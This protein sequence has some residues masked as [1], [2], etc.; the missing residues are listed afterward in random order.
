MNA[1]QVFVAALVCVILWTIWT[2]TKCLWLHLFVWYCEQYEH[3]PSVCGCTCLCDIVNNMNT[4][5]VFVAALVC[6][7]L[8]T[9]WTITKCLW[10]HLFAWYCEQYECSPSVC[11]CTCL[12][13]IV[14]NMN[15]HQVFVAALVCVILWTIWTL[16]KCLWLHLF[17]WYCEQYERSPSVCGYTCL[18]DIVNNMNTHQVFVATLVCV[19]LWTIWTLTKCLWL[20]LFAWYCEQYEHSPSVC[21]CTCL[22]DI[23]NN[24]NA[25]QVFVAALVCVILWTIWTLTKCLWLHLFAWYCEQ[26]EH[27]P[28]V[29]G[30]TCLRDIVNNMNT[31]QVFVAALVCVILWTMWMLTKCLWLHLFAWYCEQYEH[32]PSVCGYTCLCDIVNNMNAHQ[33]FVACL[34]LFAWYCEQYERSPSSP[35]VCGCTC[36]RDIVNNMNT[37]QVF[38]ATLVCVILWT[39]WTLTKCL[40]LHLFAWYCEQYEHSP[41]VCGCTCLRDIVNNMNAHQVFVAALVCVILW[42]I[43]TLTKCLWLHL[44]ACDI[45]NNMNTHQ[46]FVA[47]LVCVILWTTFHQVFVA[48]LVCVILWCLWLHL[49]AWYCEQYE[50][51]PSVCGCTCLRDIVNNMNAHQVFV[52]ALVC[53]ILWT[54]WTLTKC[55]WLHLFAWYCDI[56]NNM[57]THQVFVAALVCVILWTIWTLTKCL[58]LHLFAWYCEQHERSPSVCGCTCL[59]DIVNNMNTHQVF[60]AT[61]VCVILWTIWTLTKC[62]W[63]HLFLWYCEQY[64]HSPSVCGCTCLRDIVNN[65]N[66]HQVFVATLVCVILWTIWTLTK[67]LWLHLFAWYCEQYERSPSVCG[68]LHLFA[69]YCEQYEHSPSVCGCTCLRDIV[70]NMNAHQVFVAALVCVIL[71]T[72]WT[73]QVFVAHQVF[74]CGCTCL[75]DIVNNMNTHQVFVAALVCVILWT[76]WTLTKCLWLHLFAWYCEQYERSPSVC[77]CTCLRDI[78]NNMNTHQVFVA[79]LVC[80]C[81]LRDI[82]WTIWTLT[83]C[84]WLHLFAWYCEQYERSPSVC[85]CTCLCDIVNNM[86]THQVFVAALVCV[87]LWT[88]WTLTKCLW[89]HLFVWYCEQYEHSPSVCGC[90][91][92]C[93]IVNNMNTHQVFVAALVC[94]ILWTIWTITKCLWLHLFAWYCEQYECSPSVCGCTC[95]RDIVNNMNAHQVFVAALVCVILWTIWTLTKCLWLHLFVWY[96]EQYE[97]SPSVCGYTCLRDIVNNMNTHQ[98]FVATLVCVILWTIW[99]L[100]K[101]LWLHLFAWYCEQYEHS[102]SVCGC[103]CLC[104]IVNNMNAH[105]V[106][107]AALVCVILWTIWTLTKCLWLHLFAWYCEQYE[108]SPSVCGCT[109]LR[110]IVNNMNTHQVFVAA[111]VCVILWT[112]WMLTKFLWLHLFAWYCEQY[113]HSPSVCGYTCLCDIVNN[114]NAHQVFVA[115][116]VC[117]ILWTTWTLT[118]CLWLHL[119]AWYCEQYEHSPSVCGCTCLC[120]I[121]NNMNTHQVFVAALVC[122]ILWTTWTLTKCLWLNLFAWYCEQYECSPSVCGCTCLRDIVNNMNTHQ[123]FVATLV[124]VILWTIWTLTKCLWLHLF[125][126]YCEQ[127]ERSPS[128]CGCTCLCDIVN[129]MN[130][131]QVF[132]AA[133]VCVILWTIWTLTKCLWLHLFVWYCEQYEHSPSVCG[134]TCLRDIVNNMNAHQVFVA[135][136]VCVILWTIWTLTKCLW[137]HLFVWY[138]EQYERSPS[139]CGCTCLRDIVNNMNTHQVFVA[140]LVCVILWTIWTLTKCLWLH[141]FAWY[142]EQYEHSPSV[143]G[144]TCLCDIVN[145]M[146]T[147]QVFVAALVCVILWTIWTLTKCLWLH[148]FA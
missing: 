118:K 65:M 60:V 45:V 43:W 16:T 62:L 7:I 52:A 24:M 111:L 13:D 50:R 83:K 67:C 128:V 63:L 17:V 75:R 100:T 36:L 54:I 76:I 103:T 141:L 115:T 145:N 134:C 136:L 12:R 113:E 109:C 70:N 28:S 114:M 33:V 90:T 102:P 93:D 89:L 56:V 42:T 5:Q 133:L 74:V 127:Y 129:N 30:C 55:L 124:C 81:C 59:R 68:C 116:L 125:A 106:F 139:V 97:R 117:V 122:V 77:G 6:V 110:D 69:W 10:L 61:L 39:I 123:V 66:A 119:F 94:V 147:H 91:C 14:N 4:H 144:C 29:C 27:S 23:V 98:V 148:L 73:H 1:H 107:V 35:S 120:D 48:A 64:E 15:A 121:V 78:V 44:F 135:A 108:H 32:S 25:H 92:L 26:Y 57:N 9:I 143:C 95:L 80:G 96:C 53:V 130:T 84:L 38:V 2:L 22:C 82:L 34:H 126:W 72:I 18:R 79:A 88:I 8:W 99:T 49:F 3:S 47:A 146:N 20:H 58:W 101:C 21:G 142:C 46:V 112:M 87:I 104:D 140:A 37:H 138:C 41:S 31:H 19:I 11:G 137:L 51:S 85:G 131:H 71:W 105:Q 86:N 132:V 40:W